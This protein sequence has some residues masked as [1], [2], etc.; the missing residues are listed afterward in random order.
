MKLT[1]Y[2]LKQIDCLNGNE[3]EREEFDEKLLDL[4]P[5]VFFHKCWIVEDSLEDELR[6]TE[7]LWE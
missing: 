1:T 4:L 6:N 3:L 7:I 5:N 2:L